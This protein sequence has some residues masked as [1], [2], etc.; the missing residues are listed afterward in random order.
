MNQKVD[1][2]GLA[3]LD[4]GVGSGIKKTPDK[5]LGNLCSPPRDSFF[6]QN[7]F[8]NVR[9]TNKLPIKNRSTLK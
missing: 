5:R 9:I 1:T 2:S 6:R 3:T 4:E 7:F 8:E